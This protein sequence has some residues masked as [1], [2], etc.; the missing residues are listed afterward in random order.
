MPPSLIRS[1]TSSAGS[2]LTITLFGQWAGAIKILNK[3]GPSIK[4]ASLEA[5]VELLE[6]IKK[7]VKGHIRN[8]DLG[9]RPL[10]TWYAERRAS[11]GLG[12]DILNA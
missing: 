5:Q 12:G 4:E 2:K 10:N 9:W 3:L 7:S 8:Q 11:S 6:K 1:T